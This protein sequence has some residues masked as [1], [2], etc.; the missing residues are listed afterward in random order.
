L[1]LLYLVKWALPH[2]PTLLQLL[3]VV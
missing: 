3:P 1:L 2:I